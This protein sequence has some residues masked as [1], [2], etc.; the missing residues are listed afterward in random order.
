MIL[1]ALRVSSLFVDDTFP[2]RGVHNV[3]ILL[4]LIFLH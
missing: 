4:G 3:P 2:D 1:Q